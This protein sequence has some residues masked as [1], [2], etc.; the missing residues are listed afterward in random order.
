[1]PHGS[2]K[3]LHRLKK[4]DL[5]N[6]EIESLVFGAFAG[7]AKLERL[8]LNANRLQNI[9]YPDEILLPSLH[10]LNLLD[11]PWKC[12]C[13]MKD[14]RL[15]LDNT[16]VSTATRIRC[17]TPERLAGLISKSVDLSEFGCMPKITP[18][19]MLVSIPQE[20]DVAL[21][22]QVES[23]P[24]GEISWTFNGSSL[25]KANKKL[26]ITQE[27][28]EGR[29]KVE[30]NICLHCGKHCREDHCK[31]YIECVQCD[32]VAENIGFEIGI[33]CISCSWSLIHICHNNI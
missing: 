27:H 25:L 7:L 8:N 2:F 10:D 23:D 16:L 1:M 26:S 33:F 20:K 18:P 21:T 6:C 19:T 3:R 9:E 14:L 29:W 11:N 22:C 24:A 28:K 13:H 5:S 4:L 31:L 32:F 15:W 30:R 12:D 17:H